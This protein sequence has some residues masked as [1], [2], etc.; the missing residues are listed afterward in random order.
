MKKVVVEVGEVKEG[1]ANLHN[2]KTGAILTYD[3][4]LKGLPEYVGGV[5]VAELVKLKKA[6]FTA[7]DIADMRVAG[8]L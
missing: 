3:A 6:G 2:P 7:G 8:V 1:K 4:E 5:P